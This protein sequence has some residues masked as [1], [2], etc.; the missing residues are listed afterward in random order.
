MT[1]LAGSLA[2]GMLADTN[3]IPPRPPIPHTKI[4]KGSSPQKSA[5]TINTKTIY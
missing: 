1:S 2:D 3:L 5:E 4:R